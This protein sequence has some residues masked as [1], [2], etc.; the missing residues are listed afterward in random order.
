MVV[1]LFDR[2][3]F[4]VIRATRGHTHTRFSFVDA[5]VMGR[6][7]REEHCYVTF[8]FYSVDLKSLLI[9]LPYRL[10]SD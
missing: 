3:A 1:A 4:Q 10:P 2:L 6:Y 9:F 5:G 8:D 7:S